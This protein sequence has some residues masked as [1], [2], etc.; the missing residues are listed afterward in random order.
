MK[1]AQSIYAPQREITNLDDCCFYHTIDWP[2]CGLIRGSWDLRNS[3]DTYLGNVSFT[4]KRVLE[5]GTANGFFCFEMEKRGA[6][7]VAYDLSKN[8][9]WDIVPY[10][11][12]CSDEVFK[13]RRAHIDNLNNAWWLGHHLNR[14]SARVVYGSVYG[15]PKE[16]GPVDISTFGCILLHLRDPFLALQKAAA[17]TM[18]TI[19]VTDLVPVT[20]KDQLCARVPIFS[21]FWDLLKISNKYFKSYLIFLP[22][23]EKE[24]PLDAWWWLPPNL[25]CE[26]LKILGFRKISITYH[27]Q[28]FGDSKL[29]LYTVVGTKI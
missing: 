20:I 9:D 22:N 19:I 10:A 17:L 25:V 1:N 15:I 3:F 4:G 2:E 13:S 26:Y 27:R 16:I 29:Y 5:V 18:E 14:S 8:D 21:K 24:A 7:V 28:S 12:V 11:G 6:E 23:P